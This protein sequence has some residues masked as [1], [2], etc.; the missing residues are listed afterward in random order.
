MTKRTKHL[1]FFKHVVAVRPAA[2]KYA[3]NEIIVML[4]LQLGLSCIP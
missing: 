2:A 4:S 3:L 1:S